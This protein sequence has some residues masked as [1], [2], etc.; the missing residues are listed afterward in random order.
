[1]SCWSDWCREEAKR[2]LRLPKQ[3][4]H[5]V[6]GKRVTY[7]ELHPVMVASFFDPVAG[8]KE[9][10]AAIKQA[11]A[12]A[13][14]DWLTA[15][16]RCL[17]E[18]AGAKASFTTDDLWLALSATGFTTP[19]GRALGAV[20]RWGQKEGLCTPTDKYLP[21]ER[22]SAHRNPKRVWVSWAAE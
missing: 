2:A 5:C 1:M 22:K 16:R 14:T 9:A 3:M 4:F 8:A 13:D 12:N 20:M 15:A 7:E 6:H 17:R 19:E 11:E 10:T 21:S 18:V